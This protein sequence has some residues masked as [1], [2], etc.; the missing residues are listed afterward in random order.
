MKAA[1]STRP[2]ETPPATVV[3]IGGVPLAFGLEWQPVARAGDP[4]AE[5]RQAREAGFRLVARL[6]DGSLLGL[7]RRVDGAR[8]A[9]SA[10]ALLIARFAEQGA[11][12]CLI[13]VDERVALVGLMDRRPVPGFDRLLPDLAAAQALLAEFRDMHPDRPVRVASHLPGRE[14]LGDALPLA[15]LF[16]QPDPETRLRPLP[17]EQRRAAWCAAAVAATLLAAGATVVWRL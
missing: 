14:R 16:D 10:V 15:M 13:A 3:E 6:P 4:R 2:A 1:A 11:E 7:A 8:R 17:G 12:V 9:H 5:L